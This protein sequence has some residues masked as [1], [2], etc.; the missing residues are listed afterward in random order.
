[1]ISLKRFQILSRLLLRTS[2]T[3]ISPC[4]RAK[5]DFRLILSTGTCFGMV[6]SLINRARKRCS[7]TK[8]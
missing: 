3:E 5:I 8:P 6:V 1:M 2:V 4:Q 7:R